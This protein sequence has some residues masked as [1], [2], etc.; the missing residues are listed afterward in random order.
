MLSLALYENTPFRMVLVPATEQSG[1][2]VQQWRFEN[3]PSR[4]ATAA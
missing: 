1:R 4:H 3:K 2:K